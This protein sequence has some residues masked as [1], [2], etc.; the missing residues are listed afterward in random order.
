MTSYAPRKVLFSFVMS[1]ASD[2]GGPP[3]WHQ[4]QMGDPPPLFGAFNG[5]EDLKANKQRPQLTVA[6]TITCPP[7]GHERKCE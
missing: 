5:P 3:P 6:G 4:V 7:F 2:F 1:G